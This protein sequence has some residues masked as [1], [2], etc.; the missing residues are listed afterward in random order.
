M[1]KLVPGILLICL[2]IG[3]PLMI[4]DALSTNSQFTIP[5]GYKKIEVNLNK[6]SRDNEMVYSGSLKVPKKVEFYIQS[7]SPE[8]KYLTISSEKKFIGMSGNETSFEVGEFTKNSYSSPTFLFGTGKYN[9]FISN[10]KAKGKL[11]IGYKEIPIKESDFERLSKIDNG[12]LNNPPV[13]YK[14]IYSTDLSE[15]Y[16]SNETIYKINLDRTKLVGLSIYTNSKSG[17]VKVDFIGKN[18]NY[19]GLIYSGNNSICDQFEQT[20]SKGEYDIKLTSENA[21]GQLYV[22]M[23]K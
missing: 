2:I 22:F 20:F 3:I 16:M 23:K 5:K 11:I 4:L 19:T 13:G 6:Q 17:N 12:N 1:K 18:S 9:I 8:E 15:K 14:K 21:D 7:D 10:E